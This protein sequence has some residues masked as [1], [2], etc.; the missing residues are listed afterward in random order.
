MF[1]KIVLLGS[2]YDV[3]GRVSADCEI[4]VQG[5]EGVMKM[6]GHGQEYLTEWR[7]MCFLSQYIGNKEDSKKSAP[8]RIE[9]ADDVNGGKIDFSPCSSLQWAA[10]SQAHGYW[11]FFFLFSL[12][13]P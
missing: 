1:S 7:V 9:N 12:F 3:V 2:G 6:E 11:L 13:P 5:R 10:F 8:L 4:I